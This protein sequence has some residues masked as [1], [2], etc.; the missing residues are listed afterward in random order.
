MKGWFRRCVG[1][2]QCIAPCFGN[3]KGPVCF[4]TCAMFWKP[5]FQSLPGSL[6]WMQ[7]EVWGQI[8]FWHNC[9]DIGGVSALGTWP[10]LGLWG[11][12]LWATC[13]VTGQW[14]SCAGILL[15]FLKSRLWF[16]TSFY[17]WLLGYFQWKHC[18]LTVILITVLSFFF[19]F[20]FCKNL[21]YLILRISHWNR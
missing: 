8:Y 9:V 12:Y 1:R 4:Q 19:F 16:L 17:F 5:G 13:W 3:R 14:A 11:W 6:H 18:K 10:V 20:N 21:K 7:M 15:T 2:T